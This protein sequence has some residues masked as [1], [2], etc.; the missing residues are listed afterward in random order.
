M[1][2]S[3]RFMLSRSKMFGFL[4][5]LKATSGEAKTIYLPTRLPVPEIEDSLKKVF[6]TQPN[7][8]VKLI[9]SSETGAILFWGSLR[10]CLVFPPFPVTEK[11]FANGYD[12]LPLLSLLNRD[13]T[14]ALVLIRLGAY[15]IGVTHGEQLITSKVGTGL[16]HARHRQGGSSAHRFERHREKQIENFLNRICGHVREQIEPRAKAIDYIVY[17]GTRTTIL[18]LRKQCPFL[19]R[20]DDCTLPSLL[21]IPDPRQVVLETAIGQVWSSNVIE[22]SDN[23][24]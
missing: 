6:D 21:T 4:D 23:E 11:H 24:T 5:G 14:I 19:Q 2:Q 7:D 8:M 17:G 16:V 9:T 15:A 22:W 13:F 10:K 3:K 20:F 1:I 18:L 12:L